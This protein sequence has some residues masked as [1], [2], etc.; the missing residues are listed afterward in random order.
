MKKWAQHSESNF[1]HKFYLVQA[2]KSKALG[3]I[4]KAID[5]Y[6]KAIKLASDNE[7]I[8]EEALANELA[9]RF[10]LFLGNKRIAKIYMEQ[11]VYCY[12]L[13][14]ATSKVNYL[15]E[16]LNFIKVMVPLLKI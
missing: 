11:A 2:E 14:G 8:Q 16:F 10:Y 3:K 5:F 12:T 4:H 7:Y 6:E 9:A 15:K 13:W 1:S